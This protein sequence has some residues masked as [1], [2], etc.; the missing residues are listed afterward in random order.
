MEERNGVV[1]ARSHNSERPVAAKVARVDRFALTH[2]L[3]D[4]RSGI[5]AKHVSKPAQTDDSA[6]KMW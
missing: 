1:F 3:A 5:G 6:H 4:R 2:Y